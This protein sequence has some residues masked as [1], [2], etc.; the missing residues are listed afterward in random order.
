[1]ADVKII[2]IDNEQ[3]NMKDQEAR[4][5]I[6]NLENNFSRRLEN[7]FMGNYIANGFVIPNTGEFVT[8]TK[9]GILTGALVKTPNNNSNV[10]LVDEDTLI[11]TTDMA[12]ENSY[13]NNF[14][15]FIRKGKKYRLIKNQDDGAHLDY[16]KFLPF[17]FD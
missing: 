6:A 3:W 14:T 10:S 15:I 16:L 8:A 5:R 2:D 4:N 17:N 13:W 11:C 7:I 1:M 12:T 9:T